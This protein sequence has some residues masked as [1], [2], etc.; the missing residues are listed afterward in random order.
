MRAFLFTIILMVVS[1]H[2]FASSTPLLLHTPF[3]AEIS[4][5]KENLFHLHVAQG[6]LIVLR[7]ERGSFEIGKEI[8]VLVTITDLAGNIVEE[9]NTANDASLAIFQA[10]QHGRYDIKV[11]RWNGAQSG[12]YQIVFDL[13]IKSSNE[14]IK[15]LKALLHYLYDSNM[16]GAAISVKRQ[17]LVDYQ[18]YFGLAALEYHVPIHDK[19]GFDIAS[20]SKMVT[21]YG[22]AMLIA[23][24]RISRDDPVTRF[25]P[26][27]PAY[28]SKVTIHHL[29]HNLSGIRDYEPTLAWMGYVDAEFDKLS[30][31]RILRTILSHQEPYFAPGTNY[32]Y[33]NS[34]Y[35]LLAEIIRRVT[36]RSYG[37]WVREHI[38]KPLQMNDTY[39]L[40]Q[41][42]EVHFNKARSY[43]KEDG[44]YDDIA[45][46]ASDYKHQRENLEAIGASHVVTTLS[47]LR[48]WEAN[49]DSGALG[50]KE[51]LDITNEGIIPEEQSWDWYYGFQR[52]RYKGTEIHVSEG[53]SHGFRTY[54][55]RLPA[56]DAHLI[57]L[58]NDGEWRTY[59]IA[60]KIL[61]IFLTNDFS[62]SAIASQYRAEQDV[63]NTSQPENNYPAEDSSAYTGTYYNDAL[64]VSYKIE[65]E[66][67]TLVLN[68]L[69]HGP[70]ILKKHDTHHFE[71][72]TWFCSKII[73]SKKDSSRLP[74][75]LMK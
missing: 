42:R 47:D 69:H 28:G 50:G 14:P 62:R 57:Y 10:P 9:I 75:L 32:R 3:T 25:I 40:D 46:S 24:K 43:K 63:F 61:D 13:K 38:F 20:L 30:H 21:A 39:I 31:D 54:Y 66:E 53:L 27:F 48:K 16:P 12:T 22:I 49:Y 2:L 64:Q 23:Q 35:V 67:D 70:I 58:S 4:V 36:G 8:N 34:G 11:R 56:L 73:F 60:K 1:T 65:W 71:S 18:G 6:E 44:K 17:G 51:V 41:H 7:V 45:A 29:V 68:S 74:V 15:Q 72:N 55:A 5:G 19:T 52:Y 37:E 33:S 26:E 59:Y